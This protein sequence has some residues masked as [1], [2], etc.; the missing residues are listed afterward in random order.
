MAQMT[1]GV[2]K[3]L[4][5]ALAL[6]SEDRG[7]VIDRLIQSLDEAPAQGGV[8]EAW[9][10]EVKRRLDDMRSGK[11]E[12]IPAEEVRRWFAALLADAGK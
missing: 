10:V 3:V 4:E 11:T 2:S 5:E 8:E 1:P 7:L 9:A 6:S 12:M